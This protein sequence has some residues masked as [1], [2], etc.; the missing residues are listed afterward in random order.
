CRDRARAEGFA[1]T[2]LVQPLH[3][4]DPPRRYRTIVVCGV[5][6]LGSTRAEDEEALRRVHDC[7]EPGGTLLLDNQVPYS[8]GRWPLWRAEER[9]NLPEDWPPS[10]DERE[11]AEDG[12]EYELRA[13]VLSLDPLDQSIAFELRADKWIGGEHVAAEEHALTMRMYF[14]DEL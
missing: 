14:R 5:L 11:R 8:S 1:P 9:R 13:R 10:D 2:L 6:G 7:L 12:S 4:L 3:E